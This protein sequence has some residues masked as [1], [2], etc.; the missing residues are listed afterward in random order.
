MAKARASEAVKQA[1]V[2]KQPKAADAPPM[3]RDRGERSPTAAPSPMSD[4][5]AGKGSKASLSSSGD[6]GN[7][8]GNARNAEI[9]DVWNDGDEAMNRHGKKDEAA[10][11]AGGSTSPSKKT[12]AQMAAESAARGAAKRAPIHDN[13]DA[14]AGE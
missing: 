12:Y 1:P 5:W 3:R 6:F 13:V 4:T 2:V 11:A 7:D 8:L 10:D 9:A 14:W